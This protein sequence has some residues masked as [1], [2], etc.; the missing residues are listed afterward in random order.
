MG[1]VSLSKGDVKQADQ[2]L[3]A[4]AKT[5]GS[6]QLDSFGPNMTLAKELLDKGE[7]ESVLQYLEL[8]RKFWEGE[9][10]GLDEWRQ[11]IRNGKTPDSGANLS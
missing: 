8:C 1:R 4:S 5:P 6:P 3:L 10:Q 9:Q 2:Y 7:S 11:A